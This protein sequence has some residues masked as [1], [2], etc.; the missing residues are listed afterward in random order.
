MK[1]IF[2]I[3][4]VIS[5]VI[6]VD[7]QKY[8]TK[9][10]YIGFFSHT[11]LEDIKADNN[12]V[13]GALDVSTGEIVFQV[14]IR[15]FHFEKALMEEHF[16]ENYMESDKFPKAVFKGKIS[17]L[18]K[19]DF[20]KAGIYETVVEGDLTIRDVT[21]KISVSGAIE[22]IP[23]GIGADAKFPLKPED[24]GIKIPNVVREN[25]A[26]SIEI[27]VSMKFTPVL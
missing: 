2:I 12:Q 19:I 11:T 4:I 5:S 13:A 21:K 20:K 3:A 9:T 24:F 25:I 8:M 16:N 17:D 15:S 18:K 6:K 22:V 14:L 27:S 10:G 23:D 7:A 26:R 1:S